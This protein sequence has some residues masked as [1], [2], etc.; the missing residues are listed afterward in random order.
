MLSMISRVDGA[1][2]MKDPLVSSSENLIS[3]FL[4]RLGGLETREV[5]A[6]TET[7]N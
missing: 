7:P 5:D 4:P 6:A 2:V 3:A 1:C